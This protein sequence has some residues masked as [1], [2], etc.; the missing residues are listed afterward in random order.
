MHIRPSALDRGETNAKSYSKQWLRLPSQ[1][2]YLYP[3]PDIRSGNIG[4]SL[5]PLTTTV[6]ISGG[7]SYA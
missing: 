3:F 1:L 7:L 4:L 5:L 6:Q 2:F